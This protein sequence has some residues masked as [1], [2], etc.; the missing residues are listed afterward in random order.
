M[1]GLR[2][3]QEKKLIKNASSVMVGLLEFVEPLGDKNITQT[4]INNGQFLQPCVINGERPEKLM[5]KQTTPPEIF[6][7]ECTQTL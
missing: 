1:G 7:P 3:A 6:Y 4:H 2:K 5:Q